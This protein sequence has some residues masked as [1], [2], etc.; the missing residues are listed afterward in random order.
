MLLS[1]PGDSRDVPQI[2]RTSPS[3]PPMHSALDEVALAT[4][5]TPK[6]ILPQPDPDLMVISESND[7]RMVV[8]Q[9]LALYSPELKSM[10]DKLKRDDDELYIPEETLVVDT[11]LRW[12]NCLPLA[13]PPRQGMDPR[14]RLEM[15]LRAACVYSNTPVIAA[16]RAKFHGDFTRWYPVAALVLATRWGFEEE[17]DA[18]LAKSH[19]ETLPPTDR[20]DLKLW[21]S[22]TLKYR[23]RIRDLRVARARALAGF[24]ADFLDKHLVWRCSCGAPNEHNRPSSRPLGWREWHK[25]ALVETYARPVV[26]RVCSL[27]FSRACMEQCG[28]CVT[29]FD[30]VNNDDKDKETFGQKAINAMQALPILLPERLKEDADDDDDK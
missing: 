18:A 10:I 22:L 11:I 30:T 20:V 27:E 23:L 4:Q 1:D 13:P 7:T 25:R 17:R 2:Y 16:V 5:H 14:K 8:R 21:N 24:M 19:S 28:E 3:P 15:L 9:R 12:A 6:S 29:T 26:D